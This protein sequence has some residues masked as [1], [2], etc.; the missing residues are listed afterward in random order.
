MEK[1]AVIIALQVFWNRNQVAFIE[2]VLLFFSSKTRLIKPNQSG[3][4]DYV[5]KIALEYLIRKLPCRCRQR[6]NQNV[7]ILMLQ[8]IANRMLKGADYKLA[9]RIAEKMHC[10]CHTAKSSLQTEG[11][12]G[13]RQL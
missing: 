7:F 4:S 1:P 9:Q 5:S 3:Y 6:S 13:M 12:W 2:P 11:R 10:K 8:K